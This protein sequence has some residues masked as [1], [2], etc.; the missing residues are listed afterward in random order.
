[1]ALICER[2]WGGWGG[3]SCTRT[4]PSLS[5]NIWKLAGPCFLGFI[6]KLKEV[7]L[8]VVLYG[9]ALCCVVL[10]N[11]ACCIDTYYRNWL[12]DEGVADALDRRC[13]RDIHNEN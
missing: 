13:G 5:I 10:Q 1:M 8:E 11:I 2:G 4:R 9:I 7:T 12:Q 3:T 6:F